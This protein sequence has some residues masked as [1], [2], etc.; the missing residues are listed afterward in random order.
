MIEFYDN[1]A[2][3][4]NTFMTEMKFQV[5]CVNGISYYIYNLPFIWGGG[6]NKIP[7]L[8]IKHIYQQKD[9][10]VTLCIEVSQYGILYFLSLEMYDFFGICDSIDETLSKPTK[11]YMISLNIVPGY[12][13]NVKSNLSLLD[14]IKFKLNRANYG[15]IQR[16]SCWNYHYRRKL[17]FYFDMRQIVWQTCNKFKVS[18]RYIFR[19]FKPELGALLC[20]PK[21]LFME[22]KI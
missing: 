3:L 13:I 11:S 18:L 6:D 17:W 4:D 15:H 21:W 22:H 12:N 14:L 19:L 5:N 9:E 7:G 1:H 10:T 16:T 8:T 20:P 2:T